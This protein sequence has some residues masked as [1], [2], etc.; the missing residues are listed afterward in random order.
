MLARGEK[1]ERGAKLI[2]VNKNKSKS[3]CQNENSDKNE[4]AFCG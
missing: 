1:V 2:K 3:K 4:K